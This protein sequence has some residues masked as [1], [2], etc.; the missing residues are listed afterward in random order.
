MAEA[1]AAIGAFSAIVTVISEF[2]KV[3]KR[4]KQCARSLK[5]AKEEFEDISKDIKDF[6][7]QMRLFKVVGT[8]SEELGSCITIKASKIGESIASRGRS[9]IE[10]IDVLLESVQ[11]LR[12]DADASQVKY[13][14]ARWKWHTQKEELAPVLRYLDSVK[15]SAMFLIE[16]IQ[17][18]LNLTRMRTSNGLLAREDAEEMLVATLYFGTWILT[19]AGQSSLQEPNQEAQAQVQTASAREFQAA[20][21]SG[22]FS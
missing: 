4:V 11:N 21:G 22:F 7:Q 10:R 8:Q 6:I 3:R 5:Y 17:L 14:I 15:L 2:R 18:D 19:L 13:L 1:L 20:T 12:S 9:S 16:I